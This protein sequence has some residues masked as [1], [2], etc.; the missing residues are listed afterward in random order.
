[1]REGNLAM[2]IT[3]NLNLVYTCMKLSNR[4]ESIGIE[5]TDFNAGRITLETI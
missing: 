4:K 1:M 5:M 3:T 2:K